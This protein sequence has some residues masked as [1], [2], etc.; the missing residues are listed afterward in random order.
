MA[1]ATRNTNLIWVLLHF[2]VN[3]NVYFLNKAV[4][5][6]LIGEYDKVF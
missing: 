1:D 2:W 3:G 4:R 6:H 5:N